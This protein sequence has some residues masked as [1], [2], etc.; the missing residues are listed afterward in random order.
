MLSEERYIR[1][2]TGGA[3]KRQLRP[4]PSVDVNCPDC[5]FQFVISHIEPPGKTL[6]IPGRVCCRDDLAAGTSVHQE[7]APVGIAFLPA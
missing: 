3:A 4:D 7:T 5:Q 1:A 2:K 6:Y